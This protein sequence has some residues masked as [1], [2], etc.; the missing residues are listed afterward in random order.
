MTS[1]AAPG[2]FDEIRALI[3]TL[4]GPDTAA[5]AAA[6]AREPTLTKPAGAL[7]R[8]EEIAAWL[9]AWQGR[10]PPAVEHPR[11]AVFAGNHGVA[12]LGVSAYPASVT[13]QMVQNFVAGGAAVNQIC[14]TVDADL[15]V[16]EMALDR[17]TADFTTAEA[18]GEAAC[19][20]ALAYGM[21]A[22]E[23]GVDLLCVGEMGIANTTSASALALAL[24]GGA[25]TDWVGPGTGVVGDQLARK[26]EVVAAG[27]AFHGFQAKEGARSGDPLAALAALGGHEL[28]G[29]AGAVL[30]ARL[31][32]VPVLLDGFTAT[33]AAAVLEAV[34]PGLLDH[35]LVGHLSRE[36]A[37]VHVCE[38]L[39]KKP[40]LDLGMRLGEGSGAALAIAI[41]RAAAACHSGMAT[42]AD[43]GVSD[44]D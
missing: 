38:R 17:P 32:R 35:C 9:A 37:H 44:K 25:A 36:P 13:A 1:P 6:E 20:Q 23:P 27:V 3:A 14:K 42:F 10:H 7:G 24:F 40:L 8:L 19:A 12:A 30:A 21:M 34:R 28:A 31:A 2:S 29:I 33:V 16:Y 4:P 26:R 11:V 41:V 5:R 43:A 39:N 18:L 15:R 22:V